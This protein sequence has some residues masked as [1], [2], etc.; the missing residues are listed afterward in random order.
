MW[1]ADRAGELFEFVAN[2]LPTQ[3]DDA[4]PAVRAHYFEKHAKYSL[5]RVDDDEMRAVAGAS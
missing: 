2:R 4:D 1:T 5:G 3:L